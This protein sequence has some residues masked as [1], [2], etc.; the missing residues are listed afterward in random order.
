M[1][2]NEEFEA[3]KACFSPIGT[4]PSRATRVD[5]ELFSSACVGGDL[6]ENGFRA[7]ASSERTAPTQMTM[8]GNAGARTHR[9][10]RTFH[11]YASIPPPRHAQQNSHFEKIDSDCAAD[12]KGHAR[13]ISVLCAVLDQLVAGATV[14]QRWFGSYFITSYGRTNDGSASSSRVNSVDRFYCRLTTTTVVQEFSSN[15]ECAHDYYHEMNSRH[16]LRVSNMAICG[17]SSRRP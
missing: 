13:V 17:G 8:P 9:V 3:A 11:L 4:P 16:I 6:L 10:S 2:Q 12:R 5:L 15:K 7:W 1:E 14:T